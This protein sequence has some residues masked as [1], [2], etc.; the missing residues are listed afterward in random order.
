MYG[1]VVEEGVCTGEGVVC[2]PLVC[3]GGEVLSGN[4]VSGFA[5]DGS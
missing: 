4:L 3:G 5:G 2:G 1:R